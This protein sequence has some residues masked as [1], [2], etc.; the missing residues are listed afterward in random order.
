MTWID[1]TNSGVGVRENAENFVNVGVLIVNGAEEIGCSMLV[2]GTDF[3]FVATA[4]EVMA[5]CDTFHVHDNHAPF[6]WMRIDD[7][8]CLCKSQ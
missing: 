5:F 1:S 2:T 7:S 6:Y 3:V 4:H 8:L